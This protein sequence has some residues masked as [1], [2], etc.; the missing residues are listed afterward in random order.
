[1]LV[2]KIAF[3]IRITELSSLDTCSLD[4]HLSLG[5]WSVRDVILSLRLSVSSELNSRCS[6]KKKKQLREQSFWTYHSKDSRVFSD[7]L[8]IW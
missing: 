8:S 1:M 2:V 6:K 4:T 7:I 3:L 5:I